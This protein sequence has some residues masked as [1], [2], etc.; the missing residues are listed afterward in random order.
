MPGKR[1]FWAVLVLLTCGLACVQSALP[2]DADKAADNDGL[3]RIEGPYQDFFW[4]PGAT[5][6]QYKRVVILDPYIE[7]A[8]GWLKAQNR[9]KR[10]FNKVDEKKAEAIKAALAEDV[11]TIFGE[12]LR[13]AGYETVNVAAP[14]VVVLR[15]AILNLDIGLDVYVENRFAD[16]ASVTNMTLYLEFFD[17][18]S[19]TL[20]GRVAEFRSEPGSTRPIV[21]RVLTRW[22][23]RL[24][25]L[26]REGIE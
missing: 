8:D 5:L 25:D 20:I 11:R 22:A 23:E 4:R 24:P 21:Q 17:A 16:N 7:F 9:G 3:Q 14:D 15:P 1:L 2:Q 6:S 10:S 18:T 19:S 13:E 12:T 26:L